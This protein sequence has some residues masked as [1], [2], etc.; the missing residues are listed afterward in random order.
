M[1]TQ[2]VKISQSDMR[3]LL[4]AASPDGALLYI[5]LQGGNRLETAEADLHIN[6]SR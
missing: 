2:S 6:T 3:K 4:S 5:Y 1:M